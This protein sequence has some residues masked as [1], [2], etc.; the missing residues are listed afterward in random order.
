MDLTTESAAMKEHRAQIAC[1]RRATFWQGVAWIAAVLL[2]FGVM[3][4]IIVGSERE[5][6]RFK[7]DC[8]A[9]G[10]TVV[11]NDPLICIN[12]DRIINIEQ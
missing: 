6:N 2:F 9:V 3:A 11:S 4:W 12:G 10:G 7:R 1:Y 5:S 8:N